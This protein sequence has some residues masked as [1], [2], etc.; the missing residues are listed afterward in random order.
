MSVILGERL[1][2]VPGFFDLALGCEAH[3]HL[4]VL[5]AVKGDE[6]DDGD[7]PEQHKGDEED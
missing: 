6:V 3:A 4:P 1:K 5:T 2:R 7:R